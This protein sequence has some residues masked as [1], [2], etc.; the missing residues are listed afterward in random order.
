MKH[1]VVTLVIAGIAVL[2]VADAQF[3][4]ININ[5]QSVAKQI[6]VIAADNSGNTIITGNFLTTLTI[7]SITL[8]NSYPDPF[9]YNGS[10]HGANSAFIAK[11]ASNG[12]YAWAKKITLNGLSVKSQCSPEFSAASV[13]AVTIDASGNVYITG[14]FKGSVSFD[15]ITLTSNQLSVGACSPWW[16]DIF[17]AKMDPSGNFLWA[18]KEGTNSNWGEYGNAIT[19]DASGNVYVTGNLV[20]QKIS[21]TSCQ[22]GQWGGTGATSKWYVYVVKYNAAG[23]KAWEKKYAGSSYDCYKFLDGR[24]IASDGNNVY[25]LGQFFGTVNFGGS[26]S[27]S[28]PGILNTVLLKLDG[29]GNTIW[30]KTVSGPENTARNLLLDNSNAA[31]YLTGNFKTGTASFG[32]SQSLTTANTNTNYVAKYSTATGNCSWVMDPGIIFVYGIGH[33]LF[34]HPNGN[35]GTPSRNASA[36]FIINEFDPSNGALAAS[37]V[38]TNMNIG[39]ISGQSFVDIVGTAN[40]FVYSQHLRGS[41]DFGGVTIASTQADTSS[42]RDLML[43]EYA[44]AGASFR[45]IQPANKL[46]SETTLRVYPNPVKD[47]LYINSSNENNIGSVSIHDPTGRKMLGKNI[48]VHHAQIDLGF[49]AP[50]VYYLKAEHQKEGISIIKE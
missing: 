49:L 34:K 24:D 4:T 36:A 7:G 39:S 45:Q 28:S 13:R 29:S 3:T 9:S 12:T 22:G 46:L 44:E 30:A 38:A 37:T 23:T 32:N 50:G 33:Q 8:T 18:K 5:S 14:A 20:Q 41:Y 47:I 43:V 27:F 21:G 31:F 10:A 15:N 1:L 40:G 6:G 17:T 11:K 48:A 42:N 25:V 35:I 2:N 16:H 26:N 19:T